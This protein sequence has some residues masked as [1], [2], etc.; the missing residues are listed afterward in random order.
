[1]EP[2]GSSSVRDSMYWS[3]AGACAEQAANASSPL[4]VSITNNNGDGTGVVIDTLG[5]STS[6][7]GD[8]NFSATASGGSG[9]Y[10]YS[11]SITE[12][13]DPDG[14]LAVGTQGTTSN[15]DY[16]D[17]TISTTYSNPPPPAPPNPPPAQGTYRVECEVDDGVTT[18]TDTV[19]ISV[20]VF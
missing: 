20:D 8:I 16:D 15:P 3:V 4:S 17:A 9:S 7:P 1:M 19:D 14:V 6:I 2:T 13:S 18:A 11:W 10:T 5:G 12:I